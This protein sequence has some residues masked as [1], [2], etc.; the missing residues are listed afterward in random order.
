MS[1]APDKQLKI[2]IIGDG[3]SGKVRKYNKVGQY[4]TKMRFICMSRT[5]N[6]SNHVKVY[7]IFIK[8]ADCAKGWPAWPH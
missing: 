1:E 6:R 3:A 8:L 2:V 5:L 7:V 4:P